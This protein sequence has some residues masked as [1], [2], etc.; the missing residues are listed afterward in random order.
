MHRHSSHPSVLKRAPLC[1]ALSYVGNLVL[2]DPT[3]VISTYELAGSLMWEEC[4]LDYKLICCTEVT[5]A[6][7]AM[8]HHEVSFSRCAFP[9][10]YIFVILNKTRCHILS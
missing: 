3:Q 2:I 5:V 9:C 6:F 7:L 4:F 1:F 10:I 8:S